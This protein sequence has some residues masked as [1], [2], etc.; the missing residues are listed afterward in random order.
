MATK[1]LGF[2]IVCDLHFMDCENGINFDG[3]KI[4]RFRQSLNILK[5][6]AHSFKSNNNDFNMLM[7]DIVDG[8]A[9]D[10][11]IAMKS[12]NEVLE[13]IGS[14]NMSWYTTVGNHEYY[15]FSRVELNDIIIP[16]NCAQQ[17]SPQCLYYTFSP[18]IGFRCFVLDGYDI[19]VMES[20]F[21]EDNIY[22]DNLI[23][24]KNI[25]YANGS[26][27]WF[28]GFEPDDVNRR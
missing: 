14:T 6:G 16:R 19:S 12:F 2:G 22:A 13:F 23:K 27:N 15:N 9:K 4:R 24:S 21:S 28:E 10:L 8:K 5:S 11:G 7:G 17:C 26:N 25:N 1:K 18:S 20:S 3:T